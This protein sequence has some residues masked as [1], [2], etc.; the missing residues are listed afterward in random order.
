VHTFRDELA[1]YFLRHAKHLVPLLF[2]HAAN[3]V[4]MQLLH[5]VL[6]EA[7]KAY[8]THTR[9]YETEDIRT[10]TEALSVFLNCA[11]G[12][13]GYCDSDFDA[14]VPLCVAT[15][16]RDRL[17]D[18]CALISCIFTNSEPKIAPG[19][20]DHLCKHDNFS[21][22]Q[23]RILALLKAK[24]DVELSLGEKS[25]ILDAVPYCADLPGYRLAVDTFV[26][27]H[28][29][30]VPGANNLD[31]GEYIDGLTSFLRVAVISG[32]LTFFEGVALLVCSVDAAYMA[33]YGPDI[34]EAFRILA[35]DE[36]HPDECVLAVL[37]HSMVWSLPHAA[38]VPENSWAWLK[39]TM[40]HSAVCRVTVPLL[41]FA[42]RSV[43]LSFCADTIESLITVIDEAYLTVDT[44]KCTSSHDAV[45][46]CE[47]KASCLS[48]L[49]ALFQKLTE[50]DIRT[51]VIE[52]Q[53][54]R[55]KRLGDQGPNMFYKSM[56]KSNSPTS[57]VGTLKAAREW[58][59]CT[60]L[61]CNLRI[62]RQRLACAAFDALASMH[63][64]AQPPEKLPNITNKFLLHLDAYP[65]LI[66]TKLPLHSV[67][68]FPRTGSEKLLR[69]H[70]NQWYSFELDIMNIDLRGALVSV[71]DQQPRLTAIEHVI[72]VQRDLTHRAQ[73]A[74]A[75]HGSFATFLR[76]VDAVLSC[77][78]GLEDVPG[79]L[80]TFLN[81]FDN[82]ETLHV[83]TYLA[84]II[85]HR[86]NKFK[87]W[88][89]RLTT[90]LVNFVAAYLD[91]RRDDDA[92][93]RGVDT[94]A[95]CLITVLL[96]WGCLGSLLAVRD[97]KETARRLLCAVMQSLVGDGEVSHTGNNVFLL[98]ALLGEWQTLKEFV[99]YDLIFEMLKK[100]ELVGTLALQAVLANGLK[101]W[102]KLHRS[103]LAK[104]C[105]LM[106]YLRA[107]L[108]TLT[109]DKPEVY[110][111]GALC[112]GATLKFLRSAGV[113]KDMVSGFIKQMR[114]IVDRGPRKVSSPVKFVQ[115]VHRLYAGGDTTASRT[116]IEAVC[117][118]K[119][120][121]AKLSTAKH[122]VMAYDIMIDAARDVRDLWATISKSGFRSMIA[123][124]NDVE[125]RAAL[126]ILA[127]GLEQTSLQEFDK[128][129][130]SDLRT[131]MVDH[132]DEP[133]RATYYDFL[134]LL[135]QHVA[136]EGEGDLH[137]E[138]VERHLI[139]AF[140]DPSV[141][142]RRGMLDF[143]SSSLDLGAD[144]S[145][146]LC[147]LLE[148]AYSPDSEPAFISSAAY[149]LLDLGRGCEQEVGFTSLGGDFD[150]YKAVSFEDHGGTRN[151]HMSSIYTASRKRATAEMCG[152][153]MGFVSHETA[154]SFMFSQT[155]SQHDG[156]IA[157]SMFTVPEATFG[158]LSTQNTYGESVSFDGASTESQEMQHVERRRVR[159]QAR[160]NYM[161]FAMAQ[162]Q[163][164]KRRSEKVEKR[165]RKTA[166]QLFR[167]YR[168]GQL[169]DTQIKHTDLVLPYQAL[170]FADDIFAQKIFGLL[171]TT[172]LA[173]ARFGETFKGRFDACLIT[174]FGVT[175]AKPS[176]LFVD[177]LCHL[178]MASPCTQLDA[179]HI[180]RRCMTSGIL[181]H[182]IILLEHQVAVA[183]VPPPS[184]KRRK[185][186][187]LVQSRRDPNDTRWAEV[188]ALH[189]A[190]GDGDALAV[191][192]SEFL[193]PRWTSAG[194][195]A[196][197]QGIKFEAVG[198]FDQA[199]PIFDAILKESADRLE[200]CDA[201]LLAKSRDECAYQ[202]CRWNEL[203][204]DSDADDL[205]AIA[206][207]KGG[208]RSA[209]QLMDCSVQYAVSEVVSAVNAGDQRPIPFSKHFVTAM[210]DLLK[211]AAQGAFVSNFG[212]DLALLY[213]AVGIHEN[214]AS[215]LDSARYYAAK[216]IINFCRSW[217]SLHPLMQTAR[218]QVLREV[219]G[220]VEVEEILDVMS[221][222]RSTDQVLDQADVLMARWIK[223][224]PA[225]VCVDPYPV[226]ESAVSRRELL[227][228]RVRM[229][230]QHDMEEDATNLDGVLRGSVAN[231]LGA[232][233]RATEKS[234]THALGTQRLKATIAQVKSSR[235][236][237][238]LCRL[239][240]GFDINST[241][242]VSKMRSFKKNGQIGDPHA[243]L[244]LLGALASYTREV[245]E[246]KA[247]WLESNPHAAEVHRSLVAEIMQ[248]LA[249]ADVPNRDRKFGKALR[250]I[251]V[252]SSA[253]FGGS[254]MDTPGN[255]CDSAMSFMTSRML[256]DD[257][258]MYLEGAENVSVTAGEAH[259]HM[260]IFAKRCLDEDVNKTVKRG[261]LCTL[262][263]R[264]T[265]A[266]MARGSCSAALKFPAILAMACS[267]EALDPV[268]LQETFEGG[269]APVSSW[270][271]L[272]WISQLIPH[273]SKPSANL[274]QPIFTRLSEEYPG[275]LVYPVM[276]SFD[277]VMREGSP[278]QKSFAENLRRR[279]VSPLTEQFIE[280]LEGLHDPQLILFDFKDEEPSRESVDKLRRR[281]G[282]GLSRDSMRD[283][284]G[285]LRKFSA[286]FKNAVEKLLKS[287][288]TDKNKRDRAIV[289]VSRGGGSKWDKEIAKC[290]SLKDYS[291]WLARFQ[292]A[293][294]ADRIEMP[295]QYVSTAKPRPETHVT[296]DSVAAAVVR[297][298][299]M[300]KPKRITFRGSNARNYHFLA[301]GGEDLRQDERII[302]VFEM[303]NSFFADD[304]E[305]ASRS[306]HLRTYPV[307]PMTT[308][309]GLLGWV[310]NTAVLKEVMDAKLQPNDRDKVYEEHKKWIPYHAKGAAAYATVYQKASREEALQRWN[311]FQACVT[312]KFALRDGLV[313]LASCPQACLELKRRFGRSLAAMSAAQYILGIGDRHRSNTLVDVTT[314][315][316]VG[317]DFGHAFGS[318]CTHLRIPELIPFRLTPQLVH[319]F[320][321]YRTAGWFRLGMVHSMSALRKHRDD[322]L[323]ALQVFVE[324][325]LVEWTDRAAADNKKH[326]DAADRD[327]SPSETARNFCRRLIATAGCKLDL[328]NPVYVM[329]SD[330]AA[331]HKGK[332]WFESA[333]AVIQGTAPQ[334]RYEALQRGVQCASVSEQVDCLIDMASD[335]NIL[336]RT[337]FGWDAWA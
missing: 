259:L 198:D 154:Q 77:D 240:V 50:D 188:A 279:V 179:S 247:S 185:A 226:W 336:A 190:L 302:Q 331:G 126:H 65:A 162:V 119:V 272:R 109:A 92:H 24:P 14:L 258:P 20:L 166:A 165:S 217:N 61:A 74:F 209:R 278:Q 169:P 151:V 208:R 222:A 318:A 281:L 273:L 124:R 133:T 11:F 170:A 36:D 229:L 22:L 293:D 193:G 87:Q 68:L 244:P 243:L 31:K 91:V 238:P 242:I 239:E 320:H 26:R 172:V 81:S 168:D 283:K 73:R 38:P 210:D 214:S 200:E 325:P 72:A 174:S 130:L 142:I 313:D 28:L 317:I 45:Q 264:H 307:F 34:R 53:F 114:S 44:D 245:D 300:R 83:Q 143:W 80:V 37:R 102:E 311:H 333:V 299:S 70:G 276:I 35:E 309:I 252:V 145:A 211:T 199:L 216:G 337:W 322:L 30:D 95:F 139:K 98:S 100:G 16:L 146:R 116:W 155:Q 21:A 18:E 323:A 171:A 104:D 86:P 175:P 303:M 76:A 218:T 223:R 108:G 194:L 274:V 225:S 40:V 220:L 89:E 270:L 140:D 152:D 306:L 282:I 182:G 150:E 69:R 56:C 335:P 123:F 52:K 267:D 295:G 8:L 161:P 54:V 15:S 48:V 286:T 202:L 29:L 167:K 321:P 221:S 253:F 275:A 260:A 203:A 205:E 332:A 25:T 128:W 314:G 107:V 158:T 312:N 334:P 49:G 12:G 2:E 233:R 255:L 127:N 67:F 298:K 3:P 196:V 292:G 219:Q 249:F 310:D 43:L 125:Q 105:Q 204:W 137:C 9:A 215:C 78:D 228:G 189:K 58:S 250:H 159:I 27:Q 5:A 248:N 85:L 328:Y 134:K 291:V 115:L 207:G 117:D 93:Q 296:I 94:F 178:A 1:S 192:Y 148:R 141:K 254:D 90:P 187:M 265:L 101:P 269:V 227:F 263:I 163:R 42:I 59:C 184:S 13:P 131:A 138:T 66:D 60:S 33:E 180:R 132:D 330:L 241:N 106:P 280:E 7:S 287:L 39:P 57:F 234:A 153:D 284:G 304:V 6:R 288:P 129:I 157:E 19:L 289:D 63:V 97:G 122:E 297:M 99:P 201:D 64:C 231:T 326:H 113:P 84:G 144:C 206:C 183:A 308:R 111:N 176:S 149:L 147:S 71:S 212:A 329:E 257:L 251:P 236:I 135:W 290:T 32:D 62:A 82:A 256:D 23:R 327:G 75:L 88:S 112:V 277:Q 324:D 41:H 232:V 294:Y 121:L 213:C 17:V 136:K 266:A 160:R 103:D 156:A 96:E 10:R 224:P 285:I 110:L 120:E 315:E 268:R 262:A 181:Q 79:W 51:G 230:T 261:E 319:V 47:R 186:D 197:P 316:V 235:A 191:I 237:S 173:S 4:I 305:C 164:N 46:Q 246:K 177:A 118:K 55:T 301:K 271:F 195:D